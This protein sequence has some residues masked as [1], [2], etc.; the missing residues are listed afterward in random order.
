MKY[1]LNRFLDKIEFTKSC[2]LWKGYRT[3]EEY[4]R[5]SINSKSMIAHRF[6][7]ELFRKEIPKGL[8]LDHLCRNRACVNPQHLEPVTWKENVLRGEGLAAKEKNQTHCKKGHELCLEN[9]DKY[10]LKHGYR[11]CKIC[12]R[13]FDR[14]YYR[15]K[16]K[17]I[18]ESNRY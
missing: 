15:L 7:Y 12:K 18:I 4:G 10:A 8:S 2:W 9:L 5:F 3:K 11:S 1:Y 14:K 6:S 13:M 17:E 16:I